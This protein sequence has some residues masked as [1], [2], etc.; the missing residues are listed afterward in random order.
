MTAQV[1]PTVLQQLQQ[2]TAGQLLLG[3][4][5]AKDLAALGF[6]HPTDLQFDTMTH[7]AFCNSSGNSKNL[8]QLARQYLAQDIQQQPQQ[9]GRR[10]RRGRPAGSQQQQ[11]RHP[12]MD[13]QWEAEQQ[14]VQL[15]E[16]QHA[17]PLPAQQQQQQQGQ[18]DVVA[19]AQSALP[20]GSGRSGHDPEEDAAAV[21]RLYQQVRQ[22]RVMVR[23]KLPGPAQRDCRV[24]SAV[25]NSL[26]WPVGVTCAVCCQSACMRVG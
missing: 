9:Q 11:Q 6:D 14:E 4:G 19:A 22:H 25:R 15:Q 21:M 13:P 26:R 23:R 17:V 8:K 1:L 16:L 3:H 18:V 7:P 10:R 12:L 20:A 5:L 2:L 24:G